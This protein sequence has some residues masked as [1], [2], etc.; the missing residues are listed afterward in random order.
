MSDDLWSLIAAV[1]AATVVGAIPVAGW[2]FVKA[3]QPC[4]HCGRK[5]SRTV[6]EVHSPGGLGARALTYACGACGGAVR[7]ARRPN[8]EEFWEAVTESEARA[9]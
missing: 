5:A 3:R 4:P 6:S 2:L 1:A 9:S 8:G 7:Y